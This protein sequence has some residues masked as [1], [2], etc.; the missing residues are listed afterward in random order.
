MRIP[1][2]ALVALTL[3]IPAFANGSAAT[4]PPVDGPFATPS[5]EVRERLWRQ[6]APL[7]EDGSRSVQRRRLAGEK[8]PATLNAIVLMCDFADSLMLG[9]HGLEPG[10]FPPPR[11][12]DRHYAAHDSVYF[13]HLLGKVADYFDAVSGGR[14]AL[15]TTVHPRTINLPQP[16]AYYG[17]HP[18]EGEQSILMAQQVVD[19][20]GA[21]IDFPA[22][23]TVILV[24]AG[25]GEET[26]ILGDSPEQIFSTYLDPDDF[27]AAHED[28]QLA[29]PYLAAPGFPAGTGIDRV[30]ILP[31][32]EQQDPIGGIGGGFGSLGVYCFEVGLHLGMLSLS[33]FTPSG[34]P[35]SQGIGQYGLMGYGLFVGLGYIPPHPCAFNKLLMGWID[36]YTAEPLD[37]ARHL[38]T[39]ANDPQ[40]PLA[41]ARVDISGSEYWLLEYRLQDP[42]GSRTWT[43]GDDKN[44]NGL[45]DFYDADSGNGDGTPTGKFDPATDE[46]ERVIGAEWDFAMSENNARQFGELG[47]GSGVYVWHID[48]GLIQ[49]VFDAPANLFNAD[50][51]HK[52]VDV[53]EADGIQDL[54]SGA[55]PDFLLG[56]DRD[57]FRGEFTDAFTPHDLP[58]TDTAS[59]AYTGVAF[60]EFSNVVADSFMTLLYTDPVTLTEYWA[61]DYADTMS[62]RLTVEPASPAA[63]VLVARRELPAGT[64]LRGSHVLVG[65][66]DTSGLDDEIILGG[67]DGDVWVLDGDLNEYLDADGD[68][69]TLA[70]LAVGL[71]G[72]QPVAWN[73]PPALGNIDGDPGPEIVLTAAD[74][75]YAFD[76]DGGEVRT[77]EAGAFGLYADVPGC[78][79]PPVLLP[80][81]PAVYPPS[82]STSVVAAVVRHEGGQAWLEAFGGPDGA[83][84]TSVSLGDGRVAAPPAVLD[85]IVAVAVADTASGSRRLVLLRWNG[86][87]FENLVERELA[88]QPGPWA[89]ALGETPDSR[90]GDR[91]FFAAV[92][93]TA[94]RGETILFGA[95][96]RASDGG[97]QWSADRVVAGPLGLGGSFVGPDVLGRVGHGGDWQTGWP[98]RPLAGDLAGGPTVQGQPLAARLVTTANSREQY[99]FPTRDGRLF[100][101]GTRGEWE[102]DWPLAGPAPAGTPALGRLGGLAD[103]DLVAVGTFDRIVGTDGERGLQTEPVS[104]VSVWADVAA[105]GA[106][107]PMHGGSIWRGGWYDRTDWAGDPGVA[108]GSGLVDGSLMCYPSPLRRGPLKVGGRLRGA[109]RVR[110]EVYNLEGEFVRA[111]AWRDVPASDPFELQMD[112]P[113]TTTG[114]YLCRLTVETPGAGTEHEVIQFAIVR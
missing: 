106:V 111:S 98:R 90:A 49:D 86:L 112:L 31:E 1:A 40:G 43:F 84:L 95:E 65:N 108:T 61:F 85:D 96:P 9:R 25:A 6:S 48:E 97:W 42:D 45:P 41:C 107:W 66:L 57:S 60:R 29:Q 58:R 53:E 17:D 110:A 83:R 80:T 99:I 94:G 62:F 105:L 34:R 28:S 92:I 69:A 22:Y 30:L 54:D 88:G 51:G 114:L 15:S 100:A 38:L 102:P 26:D 78:T 24:H 75:I 35:D 32:T 59:G 103:L 4:P 71:R 27:A 93:D 7:R 101:T 76:A 23:D 109:G 37:G 50:A 13:D 21:E 44:G 2:A 11:Q 36:P 56:S 20:L 73:L 33:D 52:S 12:S 10:D 91:R 81:D 79:L 82:G 55:D 3:L 74:G 104:V 87:L 39:P 14:L 46:V 16:M 19:S 70:P 18:T 67:A 89:P 77:V 113:G 64:D 63:P 5:A 72:G 47:W 8:A 68:P